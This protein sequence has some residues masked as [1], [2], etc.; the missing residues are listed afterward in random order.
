MAIVLIAPGLTDTSSVPSVS[1]RR[2]V[3][4]FLQRRRHVL[5]DVV[6]L[7][8]QLAMPAI[9]QHDQLDFLRPAEIDQ[10]IERRANRPAR[11]E[12]IV[13]EQNLLVVDGERNLRAAHERL[14][15]DGMPHQ[16]VAIQRD[17]ERAGPHR[18]VRDLLEHLREA[19]GEHI[20]AR[21]DAD[22]RQALGAAVA[23]DESRARCA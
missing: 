16:V 4:A 3:H 1:V 19:L 11:V 7:D 22:E 15:A 20:A 18:L 14:R 6:G 13:D 5:A 17:V 9:D 2:T 23:L 10:R 12:H 8:R 21:A